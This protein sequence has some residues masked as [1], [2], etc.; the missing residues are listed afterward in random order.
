MFC[1]CVIECNQYVMIL[2]AIKETPETDKTIQN[3][4]SQEEEETTA[5]TTTT[6]IT[7]NSNGGL[8]SIT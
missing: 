4:T 1:N 8:L 5:T 3:K 2:V 7:D 6:T